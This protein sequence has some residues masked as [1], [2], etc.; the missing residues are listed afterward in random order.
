MPT[1]IVT[2]IPIS[3]AP[4]SAGSPE[5]RENQRSTDRSKRVGCADGKINAAGDDDKGHSHGHNREETG[6]LRNLNQSSRIEEL[7]DRD[8]SRC[9]LS[10]RTG[11][12]N[13]FL[14]ARVVLKFWKLNGAAKNGQ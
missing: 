9:L 5:L 10:V 3:T 13:P 7:V 14:F 4:S 8:E 1:P 2:R 6:V 11:L 12:K